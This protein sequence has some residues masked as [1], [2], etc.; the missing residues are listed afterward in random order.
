MPTYG[1]EYCNGR[2][3]VEIVEGFRICTV[4][5]SNLGPTGAAGL[6]F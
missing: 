3:E 6:M 5:G 4:C 2:V 1:C